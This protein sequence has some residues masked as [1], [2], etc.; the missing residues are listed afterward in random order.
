MHHIQKKYR[1]QRPRQSQPSQNMK[2]Y[3]QNPIDMQNQQP[4]HIQ[5]PFNAQSFQTIKPQNQMTIYSYQPTQMQN[6]IPL[7]YYLKQHEITKKNNLQ[8]YRKCQMPQN[9]YR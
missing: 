4:M 5:N 7:P 2:I 1:T 8:T 3:P 9:H 6:E